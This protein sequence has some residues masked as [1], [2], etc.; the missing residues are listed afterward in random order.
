MDKVLS[1]RIFD[2]FYFVDSMIFYTY[3][4][5]FCPIEIYVKFS[6]VFFPAVDRYKEKSVC[7]VSCP[8][9]ICWLH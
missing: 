1:S 2:D 3:S 9:S 5:C 6:N 8:F 4:I 7:D